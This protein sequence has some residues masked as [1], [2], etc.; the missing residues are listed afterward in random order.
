MSMH[1]TAI[2]FETASHRRDSAC[3]LAAV[4]VRD[5]QIV[6]SA[7]WMI[8]PVPLYF[9]EANIRIHGITPDHVRDAADFGQ[10]WP[11]IAERLRGDCL[12]AHNARFDLG[13]L[14][15]CLRAHRCAIPELEFTC[16]RAI[17]RQV[18]PGRRRYGLKPLADWLGVRFVHHD[19][20]EDSIAC[21]RI[22]LAARLARSSDTLEALERS[23]RL[24]RG[25]VGSW[26]LRSPT[27]T[28]RR[29]RRV[30]GSPVKTHRGGQG[31]LR[32]MAGADATEDTGPLG[33]DSAGADDD[34]AAIDLQRLLIR[35][36]FIRPLA[37]KRVVFTG[38]FQFFS[39]QF[40]EQLA[41]RLGGQCQRSVSSRT[42][43]VVVGTRDRRT[44]ASGRTMSVKEQRASELIADGQPIRVVDEQQFIGLVVARAES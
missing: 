9:S 40:A 35:A 44:L 15:A 22:L 23:L 19:A 20:L 13:V 43:L 32:P 38:Q 37:G 36:E 4:T 2:D 8:R 41:V 14:L 3:Q 18:W 39:R 11:E 26:G 34:A 17:A 42:D 33:R 16:T 31:P 27:I 7:K 28:R 1:F 21:A 29:Q 12:V 10:L 24:E 5:G 25:R 30:D 6:D